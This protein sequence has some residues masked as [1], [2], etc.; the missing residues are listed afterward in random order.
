MILIPEQTCQTLHW[1]SS[2]LSSEKLT[3]LDQMKDEILSNTSEYDKM[4][5]FQ[6]PVKKVEAIFLKK[7]AHLSQDEQAIFKRALV[8][9]LALQ[10]PAIVAKM[11]LPASILALYPDAFG[12]LA[13]FLKSIN[14]ET[15]D[16]KGEFFCKDI[17]FVL[18]LS[19]PGGACVFDMNSRIGLPSVLLSV[20][21]AR[22]LYGIIR[23]ICAGGVGP[24]SRG[25]IDSR[26]L[27]DVNEQGFYNLHFRIAEV[28]ERKKKLRDMLKRVG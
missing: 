20:I 24:W 22:T 3:L 19:V 6:M 1:L 12:R 4:A 11:D 2:A 13:D 17:R 21:R 10:L 5:D 9:K 26:Y 18:G 27:T 16:S 25:H 28:L 8:A 15:Y 14:D 23:Y 7:S